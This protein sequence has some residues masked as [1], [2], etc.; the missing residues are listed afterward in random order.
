MMPGLVDAPDHPGPLYSEAGQ[1]PDLG[2]GPDS[3]EEAEQL[4]II[5]VFCEYIILDSTSIS[6]FLL[7]T[8]APMMPA[9]G[10]PE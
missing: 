6:L 10:P 5:S 3:G 9:T 8:L 2:K 4:R 1:Q 7:V